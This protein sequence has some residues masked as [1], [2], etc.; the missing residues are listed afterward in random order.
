MR[1]APF[2][3][4]K[5]VEKIKEEREKLI[6]SLEDYDIPEEEKRFIMR[7]INH[8]TER[9]LEKARYSKKLK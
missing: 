1:F 9:L 3:D 4:E 2:E 6:R 8:I 5:E 7:K